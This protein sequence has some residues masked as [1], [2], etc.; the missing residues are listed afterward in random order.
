M[1]TFLTVVEATQ[2]LKF[3]VFRAKI[4]SVISRTTLRRT[5]LNYVYTHIHEHISATNV[6]L[7]SDM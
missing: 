6:L 5:A 7:V 4:F 3:T 2:S 1:S